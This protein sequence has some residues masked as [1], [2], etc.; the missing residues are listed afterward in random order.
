MSLNV[1]RKGRFFNPKWMILP[2]F[3]AHS[4]SSREVPALVG[5]KHQICRVADT[6]AQHLSTTK[7]TIL[8]RRTNLELECGESLID[9]ARGHLSYFLIVVCHPSNR[10]I[11][12]GIAALQDWHK[13]RAL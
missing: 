12:A 13:V 1:V 2:K 7:I 6:V 10:G 9:R 8:F 11:V 3:A 4:D 5:I